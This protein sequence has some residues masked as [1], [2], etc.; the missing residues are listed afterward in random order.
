MPSEYEALVAALKLTDIPFA[1][2]GW[3]NRPEGTYGVVSLDM[4]AGTLA[5]DGEKQ[6][7]AWEASID[8]FFRL[9]SE[10]DDII[11][12]VEEILTEICGASWDM[13]SL[14]HES[15][16]GLFHIEWVCDVMDEP[17]PETDET[18]ENQAEEGGEQDGGGN[19]G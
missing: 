18:E 13:N 6:D 4:P 3:K 10:R 15:G 16:T 12:T 9:L 19:E 14:Q 17:E 8:V 7:R 11:E 2:Y 1:E 5:G